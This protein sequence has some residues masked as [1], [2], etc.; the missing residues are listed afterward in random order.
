MKANN[1]AKNVLFHNN[2]YKGES[3]QKAINFRR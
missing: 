3:E 1:R 2:L